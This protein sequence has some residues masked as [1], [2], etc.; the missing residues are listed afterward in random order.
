MPVK[1]VLVL[2]N[3]V[4]HWP[5]ACVAGRETIEQKGERQFG[6]WVRPV[7]PHSEGELSLQERTTAQGREVQVLDI[8]RMTLGDRVPDVL[9]PENWRHEPPPW[10]VIGRG[11]VADLARMVEEPASLWDDPRDPNDRV[12]EAR[13]QHSHLP[14]SL[15]LV[16]VD[17]VLIRFF[18]E[19]YPERT[20]KHRR[21]FFRYRGRDYNLAITDPAIEARYGLRVPTPSEAAVEHRIPRAYVCISLAH[22]SFQGHHYKLAAAIIDPEHL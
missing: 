17:G 22:R 19:Q 20:R 12:T 1:T 18:S 5:N 2:A 9:Q 6:D 15:Y 14:Q 21:A 7:S 11:T 13:A 4:R 8:V 3:S 10:D 16:A